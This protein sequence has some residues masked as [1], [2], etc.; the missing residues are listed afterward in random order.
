MREAKND[1]FL[2]GINWIAILI[3]LKSMAK[4]PLTFVPLNFK[5]SYCLKTCKHG[6]S[7]V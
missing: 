1:I 7:R 6:Q 5:F 4:F 2:K 3:A